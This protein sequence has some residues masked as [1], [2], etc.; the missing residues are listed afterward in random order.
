LSTCSNP[1]L[2]LR[3]YNKMNTNDGDGDGDGGYAMV[4]DVD[5][6]QASN[7][8]SSGED[9]CPSASSSLQIPYRG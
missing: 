9:P 7:N 1:Q 4:D 2:L 3:K 6:A 8:P 5:D